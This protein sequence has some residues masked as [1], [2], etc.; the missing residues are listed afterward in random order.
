MCHGDKGLFVL[1]TIHLHRF[2]EH[3]ERPES[4]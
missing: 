3:T 2:A 1:D 4:R